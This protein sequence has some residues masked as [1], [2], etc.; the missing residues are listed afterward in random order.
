MIL[1]GY[2]C[3]H[4]LFHTTVTPEG[5]VFV[6]PQNVSVSHGSSVT[7]MCMVNLTGSY[8]LQWSHNGE[9]LPGENQTVLNV[10]AVTAAQGGNYTCSVVN[11]VGSGMDEG[12]LYSKFIAH[13]I[14]NEQMYQYQA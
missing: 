9:E 13:P 14:I 8:D 4:Y 6:V 12:M 11:V 1:P 7:F 5:S 2:K 3:A 10:N